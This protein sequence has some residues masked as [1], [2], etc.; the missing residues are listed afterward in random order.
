[1]LDGK[2]STEPQMNTPKHVLWG[3]PKN[4]EK[5]VSPSRF[6]IG[7]C[8]YDSDDEEMRSYVWELKPPCHVP[9]TLPWLADGSASLREEKE[10]STPLFPICGDPIS[11]ICQKIMLLLALFSEDYVETRL[12]SRRRHLRRRRLLLRRRLEEGPRRRPKE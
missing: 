2:N 5:T 9:E 1:M 8:D 3:L 11:P 4:T 6:G 7:I 10:S 12:L